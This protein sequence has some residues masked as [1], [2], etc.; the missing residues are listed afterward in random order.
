MESLL[1][2]GMAVLA[3]YPNSLDTDKGKALRVWDSLMSSSTT[4]WD[5]D[6]KKKSHSLSV[7]KTV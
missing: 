7:R 5:T 6:L 1:L 3:C 2:P 4:Q